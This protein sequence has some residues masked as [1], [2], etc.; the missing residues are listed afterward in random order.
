MKAPPPPF[1]S[2]YEPKAH[3]APRTLASLRPGQTAQVAGIEPSPLRNRLL[4]LGIVK[5]RFVR[6]VR[7]APAGDPLEVVLHGFHLAIRRSVAATV[8]LHP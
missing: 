8:N 6:L 7:V 3:T 1:P 4:E 2:F 5:G